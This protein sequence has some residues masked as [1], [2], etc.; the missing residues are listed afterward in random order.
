M[1]EVLRALKKIN[2]IH[3]KYFLSSLM[4]TVPTTERVHL[5]ACNK[6]LHVRNKILNDI[7]YG[8]LGRHPLFI[9]DTVR[10]LLSIG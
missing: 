3:G 1:L 7:V 2:L 5:L 10:F 4:H 9:T 8:E 6:F